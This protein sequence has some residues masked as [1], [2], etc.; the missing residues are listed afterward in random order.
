MLA[1]N[2]LPVSGYGKG[3][4]RGVKKTDYAIKI[5]KKTETGCFF[6]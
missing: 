3:A 4:T 6:F 5:G 1:S 2:S